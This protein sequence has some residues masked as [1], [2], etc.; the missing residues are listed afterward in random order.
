MKVKLVPLD[1]LCLEKRLVREAIG[2]D[3]WDDWRDEIAAYWEQ[4]IEGINETQLK[5]ALVRMYGERDGKQL[6]CASRSE[7]VQRL[8]DAESLHVL[9]SFALKVR[10]HVKGPGDRFEGWDLKLE[11]HA[12]SEAEVIHEGRTTRCLVDGLVCISGEVVVRHP[13]GKAERLAVFS[14]WISHPF[15][16]YGYRS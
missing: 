8:A 4:E 9:R 7:Q 1:E 14:R 3:R 16:Q 2:S 6:L 15:W 13:D 10:R 12:Y 11:Q 5:E